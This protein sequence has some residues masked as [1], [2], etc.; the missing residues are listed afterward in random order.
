MDHCVPL[1]YHHH[2]KNIVKSSCTQEI[3]K[4][5]WGYCNLVHKS[6]SRTLCASWEYEGKNMVARFKGLSALKRVFTQPCTRL[7]TSTRFVTSAMEYSALNYTKLFTCFQFFKEFILAGQ[8]H[9]CIFANFLE[10]I[11]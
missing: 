9:F 6:S 1:P 11:Q 8:V 5:C 7:M 2:T 3:N 10:L 4:D